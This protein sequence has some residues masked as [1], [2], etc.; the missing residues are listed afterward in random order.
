[1][2]VIFLNDYIGLHVLLFFC[3]LQCIL[4]LYNISDAHNVE[5]FHVVLAVCVIIVVVCDVSH[6]Y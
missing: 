4:N 2:I 3:S 1:M 5:L 6:I